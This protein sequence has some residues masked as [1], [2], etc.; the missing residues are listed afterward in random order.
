MFVYLQKNL[1]TK[2]DERIDD[3]ELC[4]IETKIHALLGSQ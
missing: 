1:M 4:E 3:E 2:S